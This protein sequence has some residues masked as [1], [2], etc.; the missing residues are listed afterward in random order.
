MN[1]LALGKHASI[2]CSQLLSS[3]IHSGFLT[4][5]FMQL[6][7]SW[8]ASPSSWLS[9]TS[10]DASRWTESGTL[11]ARAGHQPATHNVELETVNRFLDGILRPA[12]HGVAMFSSPS[13]IVRRERV[14]C[15]MHACIRWCGGFCFARLMCW[16]GARSVHPSEALNYFV[17][18]HRSV[19]SVRRDVRLHASLG[20]M[21]ARSLLNYFPRPS[22]PENKDAPAVLSR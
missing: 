15:R 7:S 3:P 10:P 16:N 2:L 14:L 20:R 18:I 5:P 22:V 12:G 6:G 11:S 4:C 21:H 9:S 17:S 19:L 1:S 13:S 8:A